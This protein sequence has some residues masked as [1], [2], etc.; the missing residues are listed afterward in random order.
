[1]KCIW[2]DDYVHVISIGRFTMHKYLL[3]GSN[4]LDIDEKGNAGHFRWYQRDS[5][6]ITCIFNA[7]PILVYIND[8]F[9]YVSSCNDSFVY[10]SALSLPC[11]FW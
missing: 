3:K 4:V 11:C 8:T 6:F 1:M 9:E 5:P 10:F 7:L 2:Q